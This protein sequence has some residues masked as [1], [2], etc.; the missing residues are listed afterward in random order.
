M[1]Q[2]I[3][4]FDSGIGGLS[5]LRDLWRE[6]P[7]EDFV[8][9]ADS[10]HAPYGERG[11]AYVLQRSEHV[12]QWL[13]GQYRIKAFVI[14]CNTATAAAAHALRA[15]HPDVPIVG[16]EPAIKPA[17]DLTQTGHVGVMATRGTLGSAKFGELIQKLTADL[18]QGANPRDLVCQ[19]CDGLAQAIEHGNEAIARDL[20]RQ[21]LATM[22]AFGPQ[23]GQIDTLVLGCT[24]YPLV[25]DHIRSLVGPQVQ[26]VDSG[27]AV[28][29]RTRQV[30]EKTGLLRA[31]RGSPGHAQPTGR[32][33]L[34]SSGG[35]DRLRQAVQRWLPDHP[36][37]FVP[38]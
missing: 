30:L 15:A 6:L 21:H 14:A 16:L 25:A 24:H 29:R 10:A 22:G 27:A 7:H 31:H 35:L 12:F 2:P 26:L 18:P 38:A 28:A 9:W 4:V 11:D 8:Y 23:A 5:V 1:D 33:R 17:L 36:V 3:G 34:H 20:C 37:E 32:M 19:A 13:R